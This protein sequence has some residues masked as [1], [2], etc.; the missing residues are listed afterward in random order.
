M[1]SF[2]I[3]MILLALS[4][5]TA[6]SQ[7]NQPPKFSAFPAKIV[8][9]KAKDINFASHKDA[10]MFRTRLREALR[11][12]VT[13]AGHYTIA[14]WG[15]GTGC[16]SGAVIDVRNGNVYFPRELNLN[17]GFVDEDEGDLIKYQKDSRL[18]SIYGMPFSEESE[19]SEDIPNGRY[20]Y[21]W[22]NNRFRKVFFIEKKV[23]Q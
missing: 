11:A 15:C 14:T 2:Y 16:I 8:K 7:R 3:L 12:G 10:R 13:Y 19:R 17:V 20:F 6:F 18:L 5:S 1:R 23:A 4:A 22:K 9:T 21:E